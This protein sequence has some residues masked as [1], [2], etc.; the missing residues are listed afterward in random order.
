MLCYPSVNQQQ[1]LHAHTEAYLT[2]VGNLV[3]QAITI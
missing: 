2:N 3:S 1:L